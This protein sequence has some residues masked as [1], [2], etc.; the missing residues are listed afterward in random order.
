[1]PTTP[2]SERLKEFSPLSGLKPEHLTSLASKCVI[3]KLDAGRYLFKQKDTDRRNVY[4]LD[5]SVDLRSG[6]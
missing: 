4:M 6:E 5:G 2:A 3:Q 1:M